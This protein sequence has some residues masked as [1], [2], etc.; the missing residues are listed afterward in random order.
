MSW[1]HPVRGLPSLALLLTVICLARPAAGADEFWVDRLAISFDD[2][3][4]MPCA[5]FGAPFVPLTTYLV[6]MGPSFTE[7]HGW[8]AAIRR[9]NGSAPVII[10]ATIGMGG[11]NDAL[12]PEFR[13]AFPSPVP[14]SEWMV[15]ATMQVLP[16]SHAEC[17]V[18]TGLR[19]PSLPDERPLVWPAAGTPMV[20]T[21]QA[22]WPN[23]ATA[24][25]GGCAP[26]PESEDWCATVVADEAVSWGGVKARYR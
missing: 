26:I 5:Y 13:V 11:Q 4:H 7:L 24:G 20:I 1:P 25:T 19:S 10:S 17:L 14:T 15:L 6:L 8:E 9:H 12:A 22:L 21:R 2:E 23:G 3:Y 18:L 16:T